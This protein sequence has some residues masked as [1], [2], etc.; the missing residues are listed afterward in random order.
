[1]LVGD[2]YPFGICVRLGLTY[3]VGDGYKHS[4][5]ST[6]DCTPFDF[7]DRQCDSGNGYPWCNNQP[8]CYGT[9]GNGNGGWRAS[10]VVMYSEFHGGRKCWD[11][12]DD[13]TCSAVCKKKLQ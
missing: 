10:T 8:D 2:R 4:V 12:L 9:R 7:G 13:S 3:N 5:G 6:F 11:D 1:I